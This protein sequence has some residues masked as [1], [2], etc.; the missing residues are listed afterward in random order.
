M[1]YSL[2][3]VQFDLL[4]SCWKKASWL[5]KISLTIFLNSYYFLCIQAIVICTSQSTKSLLEALTRS[6]HKTQLWDCLKCSWFWQ[7]HASCSQ[8][9]S[10][11][12][13]TFW[14]LFQYFQLS[15]LVFNLGSIFLPSSLLR[16]LPPVAVIKRLLRGSE[17]S[18]AILISLGWLPFQSTLF[19]WRAKIC[20][21][22]SGV[23]V[24]RERFAGEPAESFL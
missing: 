23:P 8:F 4:I 17:I 11:H 6:E 20:S 5:E 22:T 21:R 14:S 24:D 15:H 18:V 10:Y 19:P 13:K 12:F 2:S 1:N 16:A 9:S 7:N 3:F